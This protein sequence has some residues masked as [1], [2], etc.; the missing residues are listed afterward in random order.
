MCTSTLFAIPYTRGIR[1]ANF[2]IHS[3]FG[4]QQLLISKPSLKRKK[5][6][7]LLGELLISLWDKKLA[8]LW[9]DPF[10]NFNAPLDIVLS[11]LWELYKSTSRVILDKQILKYGVWWIIKSTSMMLRNRNYAHIRQMNVLRFFSCSNR[12]VWNN[13]PPRS[14][15]HVSS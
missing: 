10:Q 4:L 14:K 11:H 8:H 13:Q 7:R 3:K 15:L 2:W 6:G 9:K 12:N 5:G 1:N